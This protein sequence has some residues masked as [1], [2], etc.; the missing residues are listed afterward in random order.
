MFAWSAS[1]ADQWLRVTTPHFELYTDAG[2]KAGR[3]AILHFE[4]VRDF[5]QKASPVHSNEDF[6]VR[7]L[8]F[9][10]RDQFLPYSPNAQAIAYYAPGARRDFIVMSDLSADS[11]KVAIHEYMHLVVR[12]SGLRIPVW[13][14]EGWADVYS[15]LKPAKDG[16]AV[17]DLIPGRVQV[18][19][20]GPWLDFDTLT[21]VG[22]GSPI[23]NEG[24]R[25]GL[26]YGE[27][28]ALVHMLFLAPDYKDNFGKF[29]MALHRGSSAAEACETAYGKPAAA[30]FL[31]LRKYFERKRLFG[32]VYATTLTK[33]ESEPAVARASTFE[34]RLVLADL[35]ASIGRSD[36]ARQEYDQLEKL[37][38]GQADLEQSLGF[39][40]LAHSDKAAARQHFSRSFAA[41]GGDPQMC[42][43]LATL[44]TAAQ[45]SPLQVIPILERALQAKPDYAEALLQ[46]GG[47]RVVTRQYEGAISALMSIKIVTPD[48][49]PGVFFSLAYAYL[50]TGDLARA[51]ENALTAQKWAKTPQQ[52]QE[53]T[54]MLAF[55]EAR[56][57]LPSPP[58]PGEKL[59][60]VEGVLQGMDCSPK[61]NHLLVHAGQQ[62]L[63]FALPDFKAVEFFTNRSGPL[64]LQ[65][66]PQNPLPVV[67]Q[68]APVSVMDIGAA[69][70]VRRIDY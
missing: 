27:S 37:E 9:N 16:V 7:I 38:P 10:G 51:R 1:G 5:F 69:G 59:Q 68:Y 58:R 32:A 8:A 70:V 25:T 44:E 65:C 55:I 19:S 20:Q 47:L 28:W 15:T 29:L 13:L 64:N 12:H 40:A 21:S 52:T 41:G 45:Q 2:E 60:S 26:F 46:L 56:Q 18:L 48:R 42:V 14:N 53:L 23:Y 24:N 43:A 62:D 33:A 63:V 17:G 50:E 6:P 61:G 49:A 36:L 31:D 3:D 67:V 39:L 34:A 57:K 30:V 4:Q 11:Y 35:L 54:R 66:G 22:V